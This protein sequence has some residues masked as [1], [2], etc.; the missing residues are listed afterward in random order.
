MKK[1]LSLFFILSIGLTAWGQSYNSGY[2]S[3][4]NLGE[5]TCDV[6]TEIDTDL[7]ETSFIILPASDPVPT[8]QNVLDWSYDGN[9]GTLTSGTYG[10]IQPLNRGNIVSVANSLY[11]LSVTNLTASTDYVA[12][13]VSST[14][15]TVGTAIETSSPTSVAFTTNSA[16]PQ[17]TTVAYN[18]G[19]TKTDLTVSGTVDNAGTFYTVV[20]SSSTTP[21]EAQIV[22]GTDHNDASVPNDNGAVLADTEFTGTVDISSLSSETTYYAYTVV[23][24]GSNYSTIESFS[25]DTQDTQ[26]PS[27]NTAPNIDNIAGT[28]ATINLQTDEAGT[29]YWVVVLSTDAAP[30]IEEVKNGQ[31]SGGGSATFS[32]NAATIASTDVSDNITG[33]TY[34]TNY[35]AYIVTT[36]D[37]TNDIETVSA[38]QVDFTSQAAPPTI[39]LYSPV[40]DATDVAINT[41]LILTFNEDINIGTSGYFTIQEVSGGTTLYA[42]NA[43]NVSVGT[44]T[45]TVTHTF[46]NEKDYYIEIDAG[47]VTSASSGVSFEGISSSTEWNFTTIAAAPQWTTVA[48]NNG[49]TKTDLTVSGTV[50]KASTI[51]TVVTSSATVPTEAQIIAGT[52][53]N[54]ATVPSGSGAATADTEFSINVDITSL[55]SETLYY[56]HSVVDDGSSYSSIE[57]FS[58]TTQDTQAPS[59]SSGYPDYFI[60][61]ET[62]V[63]LDVETDEDGEF[64]YVVLTSGETAPSATQVMNGTDANDVAA[65]FAGGGSFEGMLF[66]DSPSSV[67]V[68]GLSENTSYTAYFV[69]MDDNSNQIETTTSTALTFTTPASAP[70][71][72]SYLP[73]QNA[74]DVAID[75]SLEITLDEDIQFV[76][77]STSRVYILRTSD[78]SEF[79][80]Y[81]IS[82]VQLSITDGTLSIAHLTDFEENTSYYVL[83]DDGFIESSATGADF[84]GITVTTEWAFTT[85]TL[86]AQW[87]G[88]YPNLQNLTKTGLDMVG[89]VDEAGT[90]YVVITTSSTAPTDAQV[91][92]GLDHT[93]AAALITSTGAVTAD[94]EFTSNLDISNLDTQTDYWVHVVVED[95]NT[96]F[97]TV[98]SLAF[99]SLETSWE[100]T[101]PNIQNQSK[102][103]MDVYGQVDGSGNYYLVVTA[104]STSPTE[105]QIMSG[106]DELGA[107]ALITANAAVSAN[108][109]FISNLDLSGLTS[110]TDYWVYIMVEDAFG[111]YTSISQLAFTQFDTSAPVYAASKPEMTNITGVTATIEVQ[112]NEDGRT[113][114]VILPATDAAPSI[115][116]VL[117]GT[118]ASDTSVSSSGNRGITADELLQVVTN[119]YTSETDYMAYFVTRDNSENY[120]ETVS[121]TE[122]SFTTADITSPVATFDPTGGSVDVAL[123]KTITI[124]FTEA[125]YNTSAEL[126]TNSN[127]SSIVSLN[128]TSSGG[129]AVAAAIT[130]DEINFI[131]TIDPTSD[132]N[133]LQLYNIG[134]SDLQDGSDNIL[135]TS[136]TTFTTEDITPPVTTFVDPQ[137]EDTNRSIGSPLEISFDEAIR[138]LDGTEISN[139]DLETI[140][141]FS[142]AATFTA[143]LNTSEDGILIYPDPYLTSETTY[144]LTVNQV[145]D[146]SGN[147][148]TASASIDFT[149]AV[150]NTWNGNAGDND[151]LNSNNYDAGYSSGASVVV[152]SGS[153]LMRISSN[154]SLPNLIIEPLGSVTIESGVTVSLS[155]ELTLK[156]DATGTG[157][158]IIDGTL[159]VSSSNIN[160]EQNI[161]DPN[162]YEFV[163]SPVQG[164]TPNSVGADGS[165]YSWDNTTGS[166]V[167]HDS[168]S[169]F[170]S[171]DG[172]ILKSSDDLLYSGALHSG[173]YSL[174]VNGTPKNSGFTLAGNPY[175]AALDWDLLTASDTSNIEDKFWIY[176]DGV[177][178][179]YNGSDDSQINLEGDASL[180]PSGHAFWVKAVW[181]SGQTVAGS[182]SVDETLLDHNHTSYLKSSASSYTIPNIRLEGVHNGVKCEQLFTFNPNAA[183]SFERYDTERF[184]GF[185]TDAI[186]MFT[187]VDEKKLAINSLPELTDNMIIPLAY[188]TQ[189]TGDFSIRLKDVQN[190]NNGLQVLLTDHQEGVTIDLNA[191][192]SYTFHS[193]AI[194][195]TDRFSL[196]LVGSI[197]TDIVKELLKKPVSIYSNKKIV[198]IDVE[199]LNNAE[200][201][202]YDM[203]GKMIKA[204]RLD[205]YSLNQITLDRPNGIF[206]V[207]V[208]GDEYVTS[209][210][211]VIN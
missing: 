16:A 122:V 176:V 195:A 82:S 69:S 124:T 21:S 30:S 130:F 126:I 168:G 113:Y 159:S 117:N 194:T 192:D 208:I 35:S 121:P 31:I 151:F 125:I 47:F 18:N 114:W 161:T 24:D 101:Y 8:I 105:S 81:G 64:Y 92:A 206:V 89:Q 104:S 118:D 116:Q 139:T 193:E 174:D 152:E 154:A 39:S 65:T 169:S 210:K 70:E 135:V 5:T 86:P 158:L 43:G 44:N 63:V 165:I 134:L 162:E 203:D 167:A 189:K 204:G 85:E 128:E 149:T 188:K 186:E 7:Y 110:E 138:N 73:A 191:E 11:T 91:A 67:F 102:T 166:W 46:N 205:E 179:S 80:S 160:V 211:V 144:T 108:T 38:T 100:D 140:I 10:D 59:Y 53:D 45:L 123:D 93:G 42:Y 136:N 142:P 198:F 164:A 103:S 157:S 111:N 13:F 173:A 68:T 182:L 141:T 145:E 133:E 58:F 90:Y 33:L 132:L 88:G 129:A 178:G 56:V 20:T 83:I 52:D 109:E 112:T 6:N 209:K 200:Y 97:S 197:S 51:Y 148:Q 25:F 12:Y 66:A 181:E 175:T 9:G 60:L 185:N 1:L 50:D 15:W 75:Q 199:K 170:G 107:A 146:V 127:V 17:W 153:S 201:S 4:T 143:T 98:Q 96:N 49:L 106:L 19:L 87:A 41:S 207:K 3:V 187:L 23:Y 71:V 177:Y 119:S 36:D 48:Y 184:F 147:E 37:N 77:G 137:N 72:S 26:A 115:A 2:P 171:M 40:D 84:Y 27:Y 190:I 78:D 150:F 54:D 120:I 61:D 156:S 57:S 196:K 76:T 62:T 14:D 95:A 28:G 79:I 163:S 131:I 172:Y 29:F 202:V 22:T 183:E 55:S 74:T 155:E 180:I 99:T 32:G 34:G 94:T